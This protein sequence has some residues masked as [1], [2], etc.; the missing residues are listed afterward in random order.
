MKNKVFIDA[1]HLFNITILIQTRAETELAQS[2]LYVHK[3]KCP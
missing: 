1:G 2:T 3:S